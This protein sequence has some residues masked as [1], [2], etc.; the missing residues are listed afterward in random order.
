M[1]TVIRRTPLSKAVIQPVCKKV[2]PNGGVLTYE[3]LGLW[4]P[5]GETPTGFSVEVKPSGVGTLNATIITPARSVSGTAGNVGGGF[6]SWGF[7]W[8]GMTREEVIDNVV[9]L[10]LTATG[11]RLEV[12]GVKV[13]VEWAGGSNS[14]ITSPYEAENWVFREDFINTTTRYLFPVTIVDEEE[15][16]ERVGQELEY[17]YTGW[18]SAR[19]ALNLKP[20]GT[21][22]ATREI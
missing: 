2:F 19:K 4:V 11:S 8:S 3:G 1:G 7:S 20:G 17:T 21:L 13:T 6:L 14:A 18:G 15:V 9:S 16:V 12:G 5:E 22:I 10:S